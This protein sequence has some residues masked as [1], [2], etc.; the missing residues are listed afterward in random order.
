MSERKL[1]RILA[2]RH[3]ISEA[4]PGGP[5]EPSPPEEGA[6]EFREVLRDIVGNVTVFVLVVL[7]L[8]LL[9]NWVI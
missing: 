3:R 1:V 4:F 5:F 8:T 6:A 2:L 7:I 9:V